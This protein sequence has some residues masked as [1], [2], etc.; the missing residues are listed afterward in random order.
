MP[1]KLGFKFSDFI[2]TWR[3]NFKLFLIRWVDFELQEDFPRLKSL[4][5]PPFVAL[6]QIL[7]FDARIHSA[8]YLNTTV[9][10]LVHGNRKISDKIKRLKKALGDFLGLIGSLAFS[11]PK[12]CFEIIIKIC[13]QNFRRRFYAKIGKSM[14]ENVHGKLEYVNSAVHPIVSK[15]RKNILR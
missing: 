1:N 6:C 2:K 12:F 15:T 9:K 10:F 3:L 13:C 4:Q 5:I 14:Q 7:N 11:N 8:R